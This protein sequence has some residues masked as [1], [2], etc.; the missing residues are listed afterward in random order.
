MPSF[1]IEDFNS[2]ALDCNPLGYHDRHPLH[3]K[4]EV[5][6]RRSISDHA[7]AVKLEDFKCLP[8][9]NRR[10]AALWFECVKPQALFF[11]IF[12]LLKSFQD[13]KKEG[14]S[15]N[16]KILQLPLCCF[17]AVKTI[18]SKK[19]AYLLKKKTTSLKYL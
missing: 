7:R 5:F 8:F 6:V 12:C 3:N 10:F 13:L 1:K 15:V 14:F 9:S 4:N 19:D 11:I 2:E 16:F 17:Y 18:R